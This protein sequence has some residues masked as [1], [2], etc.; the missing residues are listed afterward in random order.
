MISYLGNDYEKCTEYRVDIHK[1][2]VIPPLLISGKATLDS[3]QQFLRK[4]IMHELTFAS[5]P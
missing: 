3:V 1:K 4:I 2:S 5:I